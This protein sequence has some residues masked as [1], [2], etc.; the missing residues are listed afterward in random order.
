MSKRLNLDIS[1][2]LHAYL[3]DLAQRRGTTVA[4]QVRKG[5]AVIKAADT[6]SA[7]G[8]RHLGFVSDPSRLDVE[9]IGILD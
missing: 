9:I 3:A 1:D 4:D 8:R 2:E 7:S 6:H 5:L